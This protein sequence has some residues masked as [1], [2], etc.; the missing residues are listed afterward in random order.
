MP[1]FAWKSCPPCRGIRA[2]DGVEYAAPSA[3]LEALASVRQAAERASSLGRTLLDRASPRP[4]DAAPIDAASTIAGMAQALG[5]AAG[6][7]VRLHMVAFGSPL[8]IVCNRGDLEDALLNLVVNARDAM[9]PGGAICITTRRAEL[10]A[11]SI[12]E[13]RVSDT[14]PGMPPEVAARA[15]EPFFT[16]KATQ[17]GSGLGLAS[18]AAR[19]RRPTDRAPERGRVRPHRSARSAGQGGPAVRSFDCTLSP[20]TCCFSG[21]C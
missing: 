15:F 14:G 19:A 13:I 18:V 10:D 20:A 8:R 16:T 11:K 2:R 4:W 1:T 21:A 9:P 3:A 6:P 17:N 5:W 7:S 12:V